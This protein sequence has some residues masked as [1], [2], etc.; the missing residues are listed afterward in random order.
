MF[1]PRLRRQAKWV[2]LFLAVVFALGFVGFGVGAGGIG[3]GNIFEGVAD[4]G[5][6]SVEEAE[7]RAA[8]NPQDAKAFRDLAQAHQVDGDIDGAIEALERFVAL[9]P[10]NTTVLRDL[11]ALYITKAGEAQ[12]RAQEA[13]IRAAYL[14]P[15]AT[16]ASSIVID[17][18][19]LDPDPIS[20][21]LSASLSTAVSTAL[22]EAQQASASA[23][24]TYEK[25][26]AATPRDPSVQLDLADAAQ[27]AGDTARAIKAYETFLRLAPDDPT[28][29][30][31]KRAL[32]ELRASQ[33][34]A[35]ASG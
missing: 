11:A 10:R 19:P 2:F 3:L 6:P 13:N 16:F 1:F 12:R 32:K 5:V 30:N 18:K 31:V 7:K 20:E 17:G 8:E 25:I 26:A 23:L 33:P 15:G 22:G 29:P 28:V 35:S 9:K 4:D 21:A 34:T 14:A 27:S 24:G